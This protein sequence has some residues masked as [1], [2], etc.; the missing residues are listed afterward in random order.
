MREGGGK[1]DRNMKEITVRE[2]RR[3]R[4]GGDEDESRRRKRGK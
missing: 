1:E 3:K 2:W 4:G